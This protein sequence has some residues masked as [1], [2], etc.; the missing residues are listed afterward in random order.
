MKRVESRWGW[1]WLRIETERFVMPSGPEV[2]DFFDFFR[3]WST[4]SLVV[5]RSKDGGDE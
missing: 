3:I 5:R 4:S 1:D 2:T